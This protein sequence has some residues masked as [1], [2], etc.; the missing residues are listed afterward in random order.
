MPRTTKAKWKYVGITSQLKEQIKEIVN[1][2]HYPEG[3]WHSIEHFVVEA[4][5]Q[6]VITEKA[7]A[8]DSSPK[9]D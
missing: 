4:L 2:D 5:K 9:H 7:K 6:A 1:A 3:K 8:T